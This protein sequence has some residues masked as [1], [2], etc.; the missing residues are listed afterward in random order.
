VT[1]DTRTRGTTVYYDDGEIVVHRGRYSRKPVGKSLEDWLRC[2][3]RVLILAE[4]QKITP[5][6]GRA[7]NRVYVM[8]QRT[9]WGNCSTRQ[10]LSFNWRLVLAPAFVLQYLVAHE[11]VH[12]AIPDHSSRFW[13][14]VQS[15]CPRAEQARQWLAGSGDELRLQVPGSGETTAKFAG[16]GHWPLRAGAHSG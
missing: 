13:L 9:K 8:G 1:V 12:M 14:T 16:W 2:Q 3:A 10:N 15:F 6:L 4:L 5:R 7:P 11:A